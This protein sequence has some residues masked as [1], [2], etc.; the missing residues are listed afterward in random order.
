MSTAPMTPASQA[1][2]TSGSTRIPSGDT[3][4]YNARWNPET[5]GV[6]GFNR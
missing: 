1:M 4:A 6:S 3:V 2:L 5:M